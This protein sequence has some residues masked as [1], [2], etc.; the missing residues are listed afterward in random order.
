MLGSSKRFALVAIFTALLI[1]LVNL[2]W[3]YYYQRTESLLED[4]LRRRLA[5]VTELALP[6]FEGATITLLTLGDIDAY[7]QAASELEEVRRVDSLSEV[8]L[9]D[10][11][12]RY[13]ATTL[14]EPDSSYF[15]A[16]LHAALIDSLFFGQVTG[17]RQTPAYRSG[18]LYLKT[19]FAPVRDDQGLVAAVLGVEAR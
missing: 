12:Y 9:L 3:W 19:A 18:R 16:S 7:L 13:L 4:Q 17:V 6:R 8:F 2:A 5:A 10:P 14:L 11:N 15:L 1:V